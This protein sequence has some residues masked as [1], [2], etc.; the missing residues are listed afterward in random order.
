M[1]RHRDAPEHFVVSDGDLV[2]RGTTA[3]DWSALRVIR[4][5]ALAD[6]P[7]AYGS[8]YEG[9][10]TFSPRRWRAMAQ[11]GR[12]FVAERDGVVV[13]MVSG[14]LNDQHPGTHWLY[15]MYVTPTSRGTPV[16]SHLVEV[17]IAWAKGE[18]AT[19]LYL[20]VTTS[21]ERAR[22]FYR[23]MGFVET[24]ERH[25]MDRDRRLELVTMRRALVDN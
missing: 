3:E 20:H 23:K 7:D 10:V 22:A 2:V 18:G 17:V 8:T 24:G 4:L 9:T 13:G 21:V 15:G 14:G 12:Y 16:A 6:T 25:A 1:K 5:E 11:D 19:E